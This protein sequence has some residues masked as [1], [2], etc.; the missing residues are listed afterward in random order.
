MDDDQSEGVS[1]FEASESA[2]FSR[3]LVASSSLSLAFLLATPSVASELLPL[4]FAL[5]K[6]LR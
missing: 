6:H 4:A 2:L 3:P 5:K 1:V